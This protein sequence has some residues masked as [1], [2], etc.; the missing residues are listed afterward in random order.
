MNFNKLI[1]ALAGIVLFASTILA[2]ALTQDAFLKQLKNSHPLFEK[3]NLAAQIE[4]AEQNS[5]KG[6]EDWFISSSPYYLY[7]KPLATSA[8]TPGRID[9]FGLTAQV[10]RTF[11]KTGSRIAVSWASDYAK[12]DLDDIVIPGIVTIPASPS[13]YYQNTVA[14]SFIQ[15]LWKNRGGSLDRLQ[16]DLKKYDIDFAEIQALENI[17]NFLAASAARYLDWVLLT[18]QKEIFAERLK[19][20]ETELSRITKKR[21]ANLVDQA[22]VIRTE[23][24]VR[25][26]KQNLVLIESQWKALQ[27]ELAVVSQNEEIYNS[28]P[29]YDLYTFKTLGSLEDEIAL[30]NQKS[31]LLSP[32]QIRMKQ[33]GNAR[34]GYEEMS[35]SDLSFVAQ[36]NTKN[37]DS[38]LGESLKMDK[39]DAYLGLQFSV[40]LKKTTTKSEIHKTNL[41]VT[42]LQ[43]HADEIL[44]TLSSSLRN[45]RIQIDELKNVI[46]LNQE[47]IISAKERT[48][49]ELKLYNQGRGELTFVIQSRDNEQNARLTYAQ[50]S[51]TYHKLLIQYT[52]LIDQFYKE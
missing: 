25:I 38:D 18:E 5:L 31:R 28:E 15:P 7:S 3:E 40:P 45:L 42:Q 24:A 52:A 49:E 35:K 23:D 34:Q 44:L 6:Y 47:Q 14:L 43:K 2:Q 21:D 29:A 51:L 33:L 19:L 48:K 50:N 16:Y 46:Q 17:E 30:L 12:Q 13:T 39:P 8:F 11:W 32:L 36:L 26:W 41:Q 20:S 1:F 4:T 9:R 22:D 27:A 37:I 10:D